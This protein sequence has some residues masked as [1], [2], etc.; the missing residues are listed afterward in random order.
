MCRV[1]A[2]TSSLIHLISQDFHLTSIFNIVMWT[3]N[4]FLRVMNTLNSSRFR[5]ALERDKFLFFSTPPLLVTA[6]HR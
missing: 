3:P 2:C 6:S 1:H 5:H 4:A